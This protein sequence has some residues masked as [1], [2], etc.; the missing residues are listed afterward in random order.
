MDWEIITAVAETVGAF[1]VVA[2]LIYL[3]VQTRNSAT[4]DRARTMHDMSVE[5]SNWQMQVASD[6]AM[7]KIWTNG[8]A[9]YNRLNDMEKAQFLLAAGAINRILDNIF[10]Q[11]QA[12]RLK[13]TI[14][15]PYA[16]AFSVVANSS[17][18]Q[19]YMKVREG[20]HTEAF[21]EY[22]KEIQENSANTT[23]TYLKEID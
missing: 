1:A 12:G 5:F 13:E 8:L 17:G 14:W 3:G 15:K 23:P 6:P 19:E 18:S 2:S 16:F 9:D 11:Y 20:F 7:T 4:E 21:I 22:W 10:Q